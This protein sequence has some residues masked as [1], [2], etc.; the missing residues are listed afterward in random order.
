MKKITSLSLL[1]LLAASTYAD[2]KKIPFINTKYKGEQIRIDVFSNEQ[3]RRFFTSGFIDGMTGPGSFVRFTNGQEGVF[4]LD[5][6]LGR[7]KH[8]NS[9]LKRY[10]YFTRES[11]RG[12]AYL[13]QGSDLT[14]DKEGALFAVDH[15][16]SYI[17]FLQLDVAGKTYDWS[18]SKE[19]YVKEAQDRQV[20]YVTHVNDGGHKVLFAMNDDGNIH[21]LNYDLTPVLNVQNEPVIYHIRHPGILF[22][23]I[24]SDH[25]IESNTATLYTMTRPPDPVSGGRYPNY[26]W[27]ELKYDVI[28][29]AFVNERFVESDDRMGNWIDFQPFYIG[30]S[31]QPILHMFV[32]DLWGNLQ[33]FREDGQLVKTIVAAFDNPAT[34]SLKANPELRNPRS[35]MSCNDRRNLDV[36][37][38]LVVAENHVPGRGLTRFQY[39][40]NPGD[41]LFIP[42]D[43]QMKENNSGTNSNQPDVRITNLSSVETLSDFTVRFWM[44]KEEHPSQ[45]LEA[46][47]YYFNPESTVISTGVHSQNAN[48]VFVDLKFP[49][50]FELEPGQTTPDLGMRFGAHFNKYWPGAWD[51]SN[52]WSWAGVTSTYT[53]TRNV[54]VYDNVGNLIYGTP[55]NPNIVPKPPLLSVSDVLGFEE[56]SQWNSASATLSSS[57]T[58]T[59]GNYSMS[60]SGSGWFVFNSAYMKTQ[61]ITGETSHLALDL[62]VPGNQPSPWWIGSIALVANCISGSVYDNFLGNIELTPLP[63]GQFS[64]VIFNVPQNVL[65]ALQG[66]FDDFS[67]RFE[68]SLNSGAPPLI[69]DNLRFVP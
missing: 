35:I 41:E 5:D 56:P 21:V 33:E 3:S 57:T 6:K 12:G 18:G 40:P 55:P 65:T 46:D 38:N 25:L 34:G 10:T 66:N 61:D 69:L 4:I 11:S 60:A 14:V 54:T 39:V 23:K 19:A 32:I 47:K 8:V 51:R 53:A 13:R 26:G 9:N 1:L 63:Q 2:L 62:Y 22:K 29:K 37:R 7:I 28:Q 67:F 31:G 42:L 36:C 43:I 15:V 58:E 30:T 64:T 27:M 52:D 49:P 24:K 45:R 44:S 50:G 17:H 48:I 16:D 68:V 20:R 59:Q